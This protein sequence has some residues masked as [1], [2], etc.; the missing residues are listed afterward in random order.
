MA[1]L[2][3]AGG[4]AARMGA[5]A[6]HVRRGLIV[7]QMALALTLL[8]C[9]ALMLRSVQYL[10]TVP[11]GL[12]PRAMLTVE[13]GLPYAKAE[14]HLDVYAGLLDRLRSLPGV[15]HASAVSDLPLTG[16]WR[17]AYPVTA[18]SVTGGVSD[19]DAPVDLAFFTPGYF[20]VMGTPV[21]AG[22]T[23]ADNSDTRPYPVL[24]SASLAR[25]LFG[26]GGV[27]ETLRRSEANGTVDP[28]QP[29]WTVVGVVAD[30]RQ[31]TLADPPAEVVYVPLLDR[32][33]EPWIVPT[34]MAVVLRTSVPPETLVGS[35][36]SAVAGYDPS[37]S[38][39]RVRTMDAVVASSSATTTLLTWLLL[40]AAAAALFLS[41]V[42]IWG[43]VAYTVRQRTAEIGV[44]V[45][46]GAS[47]R[48]VLALI[49][50]EVVAVVLVG[51]AVGF[52]LSVAAT[53]ALRALLV[54]V[55]PADPIALL[56]AAALLVGV[57]CLAAYFPAR[58][59]TRVNPVIALQNG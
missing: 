6:Q 51:A 42:G 44:R 2:L 43:V 5:S 52:A 12:D 48:S 27:G 22:S 49:I 7:S 41:A 11:R 45:A 3:R 57:G 32:P 46:L 25:R 35:V 30:V 1:G 40:T 37:L 16:T 29:D 31:H 13:V 20:E 38:L 21:V 56:A 19:S 9:A 14:Q 26:G 55:S 36:R 33:V 17:H 58:A 54:G 15:T 23:I 34:E 28:A 39:A 59:A 18:S 8:V 10:A 4:A 53:R 50:G 47:R 24:I